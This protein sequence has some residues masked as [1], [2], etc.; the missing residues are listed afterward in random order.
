MKTASDRD[1]GSEWRK[2]DLH[3]HTP[4]SICQNYGNDCDE[5]WERYIQDL[6]SLPKEYAVLGIN[7]YLFLDG[8]E[9]LLNEQKNNRLKNRVLL[10]V[11]EF[12]IAQFA[13]VEF[14]NLK[15][16]NLHVIFSNEIEPEVIK[17]QF[18][19][20]LQQ[21]YYIEK[22]GKKW[23]M[24][25]TKQS[26][27]KLGKTIK[28]S[29]PKEELNKFKS[30]LVEGFNNLNIKEDEIF[31]SL[32]KDC[33]KDKY[34]I[35]IG[36]TEW[37]D[38]KWSDSSIATK[39][40][41]INRADVV[42]TSTESIESFKKSKQK[43]KQHNVND[44]LLDCSDAHSF[45]S[46]TDKDKIGKSLTWIKADTTFHGLKQILNEHDRVFIGDNPPIQARVQN[47]RTKYINKIE[48]R[49]MAEYDG[50]YGKWFQS[51]EIPLNYELIAIIGNKGSG[52][53]A[54]ADTIALCG[55]Y[56]NQ[57]DFSFLRSDRFRDGKHA[58]NF[59]ATLTWEN[60]TRNTKKLSDNVTVGEIETV[61][62]LPQGY[63]ERLTN[64][65][66]SIQDFRKEIE[67][68]VFTHLDEDDKIGFYSFEE[69]VAKKKEAAENE[70]YFMKKEL[71]EI[72]KSIFE[73]EKKLNTAYKDS[74]KAKI[75]K[76]KEE[77][78]AL[79]E[80]VEVK[81]PIDDSEISRQNQEINEKI[82]I[83]KED[84]SILE[85]LI[86]ETSTNKRKILLELNEINEIKQKLKSKENEF[87]NFVNSIKDELQKYDL[88]IKDILI[89]KFEYIKIDTI[90]AQKEKYLRE[91]KIKLGEEPS[92][93]ERYESLLIQLENKNKELE[94]IQKILGE[95]EKKYHN[96]LA[97]MKNFEENKSKIVG[98]EEIPNTLKYFERELIH[99]TEE[100]SDELTRERNQRFSITKSIY[101]KME[102]ILEIYRTIKTKIDSIISENSELL[103][104]FEIN[105]D[106]SFDIKNDF[107]KKFLNFIFLNKV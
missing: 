53:S 32:E 107:Q 8:Y 102:T 58:D 57:D 61:K 18:L 37:A 19:N 73:K 30:D 100:L 20:T 2:W 105:I 75:E 65:F 88:N 12:R 60:G 46:S 77:I 101:E 14:G 26:I 28:S 50:K 17:S 82:A 45:S 34:L 94:E 48:I 90:F 56:K 41:I 62:Y 11:V 7:D 43:L 1:R 35:A 24:A 89:Y 80:P 42:F 71:D 106:A 104:P 85:K 5:I 76:K 49:P 69:L 29:I 40:S 84:I 15:R 6:E 39:K 27:E 96:Y 99:I 63:F 10:P 92:D 72:N 83:I 52:K 78:G 36:K 66:D 91:C 16:I 31:K 68:I 59:E 67:D 98:T 51:V 13:G 44:L 103:M 21:H 64:D 22:D 79:I 55:N 23:E 74:I 70:I 47:H 86:N 38:L 81:N 54:I 93:M 33:F 25:I 3:I 9:K 97:E 87:Q 4:M 95:S